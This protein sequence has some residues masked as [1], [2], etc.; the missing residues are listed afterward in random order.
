MNK[1]IICTKGCGL[2]VFTTSSTTSKA[3]FPALRASTPICR[4][5]WRAA[6]RGCRRSGDKDR[7]MSPAPPCSAMAHPISPPTPRTVTVVFFSFFFLQCWW[8][9]AWNCECGWES[10]CNAVH[11][12]IYLFN[13]YFLVTSVDLHTKFDL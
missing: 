7:G 1:Y 12:F 11:E 8:L 2:I 9:L 13:F 4:Q 3:G 10:V 5:W 6:S